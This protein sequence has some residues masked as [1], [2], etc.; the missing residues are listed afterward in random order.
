ML[1]KIKIWHFIVL[2]IGLIIILRFGYVIDLLTVYYLFFQTLLA[3][4]ENVN[5]FITFPFIDNFISIC[6]IFVLPIVILGSAGV[7][8]KLSSRLKFS[9]IFI[10]LL[11]VS[12]VFAPIITKQH[13]DFQKNISVT[14]LLP[15]FSSSYYIL[16]NQN[17]KEE[18][19]L[20][21]KLKDLIDSKIP[22]SFNDEIIF[23]DSSSFD[24]AF[25]YYQSG[26]LSV[27][28]INKLKTENDKPFIG[29]KLFILGT[30]EFGRDVFTR[31]VYGCRISIIIGL[32]AVFVSF[33]LGIILAFIA[34]QIGG[35]LRI[36]INRIADLFLTFP[37]IFLVVLILAL[38]G[39]NI[40]SIIIVLGFSGWMSLF[41][42][43]SSEI[44]SLKQKEFF[45]TAEQI[46]LKKLRLL[47]REVLPVII[48]PVIVN[49]IF[50]LS[51]VILAE[52][53]LSYLGLGTGSEYS[54]WGSM[55]ESGQEYITQSWWLI[56]IPGITLII[57]LLSINEA[58]RKFSQKINPTIR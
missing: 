38:F 1:N 32:G 6:L 9:N 51:N 35:L 39:S 47:I 46:G 55:I 42:I 8:N 23:L 33:F 29:T 43:A 15:P 12:F 18:S 49:L 14:K 28:D 3:G 21:N 56:F 13:P 57:T 10:V 7:K 27:I 5:S 37:S 24:S 26:V 36:L 53:A 16:L 44:I 19:V 50:Q 40:F 22:K 20:D 48:V 52:S 25:K 31:I 54:S 2:V 30:D 45:L 34:S 58:G 4:K 17:N 41:K 11:L